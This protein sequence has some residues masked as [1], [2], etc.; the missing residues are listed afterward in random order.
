L[1]VASLLVFHPDDL[2]RSWLV[3]DSLVD[4]D[5]PDPAAVVKA[6]FEA[7]GPDPLFDRTVESVQ[8]E[9]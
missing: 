5:L 1:S 4:E 9:V 6:T 7:R 2:S 3:P 8:I